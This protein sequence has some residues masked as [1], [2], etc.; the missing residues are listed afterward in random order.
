MDK[1]PKYHFKGENASCMDVCLLF[2]RVCCC[3]WPNKAGI[4]KMFC[5]QPRKAKGISVVS[6]VVAS[7]K[8]RQTGQSRMHY[9]RMKTALKR[10]QDWI[11]S[12]AN[13]EERL[14]SVSFHQCR[15]RSD[16][17][18]RLKLS[19][20]KGSRDIPLKKASKGALE[21][22]ATG[23]WRRLKGASVAQHGEGGG[24][25]CSR[26]GGMTESA[27]EGGEDRKSVV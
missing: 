26:W 23:Y 27:V 11:V 7:R 16:Y 3:C 1:T 14:P 20:D 4:D 21:L 8:K 15:W 2:L 10:T 24:W 5:Y 12:G 25:C 19:S 13:A 18:G 6:I 22:S 9:D 17:G